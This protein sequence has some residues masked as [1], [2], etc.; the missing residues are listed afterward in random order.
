LQLQQGVEVAYGFQ[1]VGL[2]EIGSELPE[3]GGLS[4]IIITVSLFILIF[5]WM[6]QT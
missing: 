2:H 1:G 5:N 6:Q 3:F 4:Q